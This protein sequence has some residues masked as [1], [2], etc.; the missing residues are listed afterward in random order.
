MYFVEEEDGSLL[1]LKVDLDGVL[2]YEIKILDICDPNIGDECVM[3][4]QLC[5]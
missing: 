5:H 4:Y 1:T 3:T 2:N